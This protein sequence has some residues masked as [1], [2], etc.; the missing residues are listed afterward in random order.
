MSTISST[1]GVDL[2][3]GLGLSADTGEIYS[4]TPQ[5]PT[6]SVLRNQLL[7]GEEAASVPPLFGIVTNTIA[8]LTRFLG[9]LFT[10]ANP[11][12]TGDP[13]PRMRKLQKRLVEYALTLDESDRSECMAAI[14][15]VEGDVKLRL[16]LQQMRMTE[17]EMEIQQKPEKASEK[18]EKR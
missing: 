14:M 6:A 4:F 10:V 15:V 1:S 18:G 16:R 2:H 8:P 3:N 9:P 17:A 5:K 13:V 12:W 7:P 11:A